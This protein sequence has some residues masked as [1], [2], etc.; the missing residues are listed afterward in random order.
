MPERWTG[1]RPDSPNYDPSQDDPRP[2]QG[3]PGFK[4][5]NAVPK[6]PGEENRSQEAHGDLCKLTTSE[7]VDHLRTRY[8]HV[9]QEERQGADRE[10]VAGVVGRLLRGAPE[11]KADEACSSDRKD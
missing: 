9:D 8:C 1:Y 11:Q 3:G 6:R 10:G 7:G 2:Q 5:K 4:R